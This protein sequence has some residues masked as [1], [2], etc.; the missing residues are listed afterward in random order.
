MW[1]HGFAALALLCVAGCG[2]SLTQAERMPG[3]ARRVYVSQ[4]TDAAT[5][6]GPAA[7]VTRVLRERIAASTV[8]THAALEEAEVVLEPRI[9]TISEGFTPVAT[10][11]VSTV[12]RYTVGIVGG[13]RLIDRNARVVWQASGIRVDE[14]F[15]PG[16]APCGPG[17]PESNCEESVKE[18][19]LSTTES[20]RRR[21]LERSAVAFGNEVYARLMEGF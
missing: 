1:S 8:V 9:D 5:D 7:T 10:G 21:A 4:A 20:N 2:Y 6:V 16:L 17:A 12:A 19:A 18:Q 15:L 14:D 3:G 11:N 13:A